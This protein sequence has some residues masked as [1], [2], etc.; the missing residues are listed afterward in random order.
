MK[1]SAISSFRQSLKELWMA[2]QQKHHA[3]MHTIRRFDEILEEA[4][5]YAELFGLATKFRQPEDYAKQRKIGEAWEA[6]ESARSKSREVKKAAR[7]AEEARVAK[8]KFEECLP[9]WLEGKIST[10]LLPRH[11]TVQFRLT[12]NNRFIETSLGAT[13]PLPDAIRLW[14]LAHYCRKVKSELRNL[15]EWRTDIR[16]GGF[17]LDAIDA[18]GDAV[19][20]C[21]QIRWAS[22][23]AMADQLKLKPHDISKSIKAPTPAAQ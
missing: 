22:M 12:R 18:E 13:V 3:K 20:G 5:S 1:K 21:H 15:P 7:R 11:T 10:S 17:C 9:A 2:V 23:Q 16:I 19:V 8:L 14:S 6:S 4:K